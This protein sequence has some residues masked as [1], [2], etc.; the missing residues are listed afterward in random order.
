MYIFLKDLFLI[1]QLIILTNNLKEN[2]QAP[3]NRLYLFSILVCSIFIFSL[4]S[5]FSLFSCFLATIHYE[6]IS[7]IMLL[8]SIL[9]LYLFLLKFIASGDSFIK[10]DEVI[11]FSFLLVVFIFMFSL[12]VICDF[13]FYYQAATTSTIFIMPSKSYFYNS[14]QFFC[15]TGDPVTIGINQ[16]IDKIARMAEQLLGYSLIPVY[17]S[18][19]F[20]KV[21]KWNVSKT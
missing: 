20:F 17:I 5:L 10:D 3:R 19:I 1:D 11:L 2:K 15:N 16:P 14:S 12:F 6:I 18:F 4:F 9:Y 21:S 8:F 13:A 7:V